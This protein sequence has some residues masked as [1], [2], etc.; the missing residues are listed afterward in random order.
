[1]ISA[2]MANPGNALLLVII[3]LLVAVLTA[4]LFPVYDVSN[5]RNLEALTNALAL[6][7][8]RPLRRCPAAGAAA[9]T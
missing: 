9:L 8:D 7:P 1:V 2:A 4:M 6:S 5:T 3:G